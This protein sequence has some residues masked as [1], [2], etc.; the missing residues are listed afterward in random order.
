M[1]VMVVMVVIGVEL[2]IPGLLVLVVVALVVMH[3][4]VLHLLRALLVL[5]EQIQYQAHQ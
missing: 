4:T 2:Q 5:V 1:V 3:L